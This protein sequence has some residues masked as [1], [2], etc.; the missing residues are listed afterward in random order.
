MPGKHFFKND[1]RTIMKKT[2]KF[3]GGKLLIFISEDEDFENVHRLINMKFI[4]KIFVYS[5]DESKIHPMLKTCKKFVG[6]SKDFRKLKK[7]FEEETCHHKNSKHLFN[8]K[9]LNLLNY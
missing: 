2:M 5:D 3:F 7:I 8:F 1:V 9:F 6:F 4:K